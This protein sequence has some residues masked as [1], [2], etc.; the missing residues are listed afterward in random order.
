[1][2]KTFP[3][4]ATAVA[5][6]SLLAIAAAN[7]QTEEKPV[8]T[9][10]PVIMDENGNGNFDKPSI[11]NQ[12]IKD[13]QREF[14]D[15]Q[16]QA[17]EILKQLAQMKNTE[18][19]QATIKEIMSSAIECVAQ[20]NQAPADEK[21][22]IM[23]DCRGRRLW[24]DMNDIREQFVPPQEIKQVLQEIKN[25]TRDLLRYKKQLPKSGAGGNIAELIDSLLLQIEAF[26]NNIINSVGRDQRDAM[27]EF[28]DAQ[29]WDELNKIRAQVELPKE[30]KSVQSDLKIVVKQVKTKSYKNAFAFFSV[31]EE[32]LQNALNNKQATVAQIMSLINEGNAEDAFAL[33]EEDIHQGWHPG[34]LRHLTDMLRETHQRLKMIRDADMQA[35]VKEVLSP[36]IDTLN[37]GDIREARD[38]MVQFG[39]QMRKYERL[40]QKYI[41]REGEIDERTSQALEKLETLIQEK[42]NKV[43]TNPKEATPA[44]PVE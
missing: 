41:G 31:D 23:D 36:I 38:A 22:D 29:M 8:P 39:D 21:R 42:L 17:K 11:N 34:D 26:K 3:I 40:F 35:Q 44:K 30:M 25:Q 10:P 2:R 27:Q 19:W 24:E 15:L 33:V 4:M 9:T 16:N 7:A 5:I 43:E 1:M 14:R 20:F 37:A 28:R 32:K 13:F 18:E 12:E 6:F